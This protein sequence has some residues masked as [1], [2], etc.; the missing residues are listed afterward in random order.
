MTDALLDHF[1]L[2]FV[3]TINPDG[4]VYSH[5]HSRMWRKNR[6]TVG[7]RK[8]CV[9]VDLN[10]NWGYKWRPSKSANPCSENFPGE[11]AFQAPE[12]SAMATYISNGSADGLSG[13]AK[14]RSFVDLH[15]YGQLCE[16]HISPFSVI[17]A[18][19]SHVPLCTLVFRLSA[20]RRVPH[21]SCSRCIK[22]HAIHR[23]R[24]VPSWAG[25]LDD[26]SGPWRRYRFRIRCYGRSMD[27]LGRTEGY[28]DGQCFLYS[29]WRR[30]VSDR[31]YGFMLPPKLIR[32]T[33]NE[34]LEGV[35]YLAKFIYKWEIEL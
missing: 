18:E 12:T 14:V 20:R 1:D 31:Q 35:T 8:G 32:P 24:D 19:L 10:S 30:R 28:W 17:V 13:G 5:D 16:C 23:W 9:G 6:Q 33:A 3:P 27:L 26:I 22:G 15:S 11:E 29:V 7:S 25:V 4:Y 2:T 21:G 34:V